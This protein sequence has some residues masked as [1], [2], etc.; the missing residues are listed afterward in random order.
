MESPSFEK[1]EFSE[2]AKEFKKKYLA[3]L[4][5]NPAYVGEEIAKFVRGTLWESHS[6]NE[7]YAYEAYCIIVGSTPLKKPEYF[8]LEDEGESI[9]QFIDVLA[10]KKESEE[11]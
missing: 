2:E 9:V 8:D 7:L 1:I 10:E 3:I 11:K 6:I 4:H 5:K